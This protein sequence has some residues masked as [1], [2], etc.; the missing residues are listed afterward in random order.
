MILPSPPKTKKPINFSNLSGRNEASWA[1]AICDGMLV[2]PTLCM[3]QCECMRVSVTCIHRGQRKFE[4]IG[5]FLPQRRSQASS[6]GHQAYN[7]SPLPVKPHG[8]HGCCNIMS[9]KA[10]SCS[11]DS[12]SQY[13]PPTSSSAFY[14]LP[15][16]S[17]CPPGTE[18][19]AVG[20]PF[21][22]EPSTIPDSH[23]LDQLRVLTKPAQREESLV[24]ADSSTRL[25][26]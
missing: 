24:K 17:Q 16:L 18:G 22:A 26:V 10:M 4:A 6:S 8:H 25:W 3:P 13:C 19:S 14:I 23:H 21:G 1:H 9:T 11:E 7:H 2:T 12:F 5:S 15:P 20:V